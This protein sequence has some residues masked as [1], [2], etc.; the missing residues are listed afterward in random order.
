MSQ[1]LA[2]I[3]GNELLLCGPIAQPRASD[4]IFVKLSFFAFY[5]VI[6]RTLTPLY[7]ASTYIVQGFCIS[8]HSPW[9]KAETLWDRISRTC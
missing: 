2:L 1:E 4:K 5:H 3:S 6:C 7:R 9:K 8:V